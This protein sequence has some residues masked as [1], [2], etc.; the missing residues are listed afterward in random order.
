MLLLR[1]RQLAA[2][3]GDPGLGLREA[4]VV[5]LARAA[6]DLDAAL[7]LREELLT[8]RVEAVALGASGAQLLAQLGDAALGRP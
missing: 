3:L 7:E 1:A 4:L 5:L 6:L 8:H 2:Q